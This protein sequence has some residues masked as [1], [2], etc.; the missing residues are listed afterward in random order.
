[1]RGR[2]D[3]EAAEEQAFR[4]RLRCAAY[5]PAARA[6]SKNDELAELIDTERLE[7]A[8]SE[9]EG[10]GDAFGAPAVAISAVDEIV[11]EEDEDEQYLKANL[12]RKQTV[13]AV[14]PRTRCR[15]Q[16]CRET[17]KKDK[18]F[19]SDHIRS[20]RYVMEV[21]AMVERIDAEVQMVGRRD[22]IQ[23]V[24]L[25]GIVAN[26]LLGLVTTHRGMSS[27]LLECEL[28][29]TRRVLDKYVRVLE[30]AGKV[31]TLRDRTSDDYF[32]TPAERIGSGGWR[33]SCR[34]PT[35]SGV[36]LSVGQCNL[37]A[38]RKCDMD[39]LVGIPD[40]DVALA[41]YRRAEGAV[42]RLSAKLQEYRRGEGEAVSLSENDRHARCVELESL[43]DLQ[44]QKLELAGIKACQALG[45]EATLAFKE[46]N[47]EKAIALVRERGVVATGVVQPTAPAPDTAIREHLAA[48]AAAAEIARH[49]EPRSFDLED[50]LW[51]DKDEDEEVADDK[52]ERPGKAPPGPEDFSTRAEFQE[53]LGEAEAVAPVAPESPKPIPVR[54]TR[55]RFDKRDLGDGDEEERDEEEGGVVEPPASE[56]IQIG[57]PVRLR[58]AD[59]DEASEIK[60]L[61]LAHEAHYAALESLLRVRIEQREAE[62]RLAEAAE[63]VKKYEAEVFRARNGVDEALD[64]L[65]VV[66]RDK[67]ASG[68]QVQ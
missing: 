50:G 32:V 37:S 22:G 18:P 48:S 6:P 58:A 1:M 40:V 19:C 10:L 64:S 51:E 31:K 16:G 33:R 20:S 26:E 4:R 21:I 59:P 42:S 52:I 35:S 12:A 56:R 47:V 49:E 7:K 13:V 41:D 8:V 60:D 3:D 44:R 63:A 24:N 39:Q 68:G 28:G 65:C 38:R 9:L 43:A 11:I 61:R 54:E 36:R 2:G 25:K 66:G 62:R 55:P 14:A 15:I 46:G 17:T 29:L 34:P 23:H 27:K 57:E 45:P 67:E 30:C 53:S 5:K